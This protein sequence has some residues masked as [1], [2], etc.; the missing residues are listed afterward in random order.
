MISSD[1]R[2]VD[3]EGTAAALAGPGAVRQRQGRRERDQQDG[4]PPDRALGIL[5]RHGREE[6]IEAP[7]ETDRCAAEAVTRAR[8]G[9]LFLQ[10]TFR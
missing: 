8:R 3:G 7:A 5:L 9:L 6:Y 1:N 4:L 2:V 10:A